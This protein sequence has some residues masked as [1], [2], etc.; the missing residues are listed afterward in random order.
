MKHQVGARCCVCGDNDRRALVAVTLTSGARATLCGS[1]AL[2]DRRAAV[3]P[4]TEA[5][6]RELLRDRR[7]R[8]D[9]RQ[10][11]DELAA[12]LTAAF[13]AERRSVERR[14]AG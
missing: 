13:R 12:A 9:R 4:R 7:G 11:G 2:D 1:H 6:L 3:K 5:E 8:R 10:D 14:S